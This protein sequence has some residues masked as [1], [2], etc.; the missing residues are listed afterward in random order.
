MPK[1]QKTIGLPLENILQG[2][3]APE[4]IDLFRLYREM[5][6]NMF[7]RLI[8]DITTIKIGDGAALVIGDW[9]YFG[10][11]PEDADTWRVGIENGKWV[12]QFWDGSE[13][14]S[15]GGFTQ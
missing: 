6:E 11:D 2:K 14:V 9:I 1:S 7:K 8:S 13:Y 5:L 15:K 3:V 10:G 12:G 4:V